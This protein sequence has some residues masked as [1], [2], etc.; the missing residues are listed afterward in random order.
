V[1]STPLAAF[2]RKPWCCIR[3]QRYRLERAEHNGD[4][5]DQPVVAGVHEI[6]EDVDAFATVERV[7]N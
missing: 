6:A 5:V 7:G 4:L 2:S 3:E 1:N